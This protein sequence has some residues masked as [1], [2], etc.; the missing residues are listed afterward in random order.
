MIDNKSCANNCTSVFFRYWC[1]T[2]AFSAVVSYLTKKQ[3]QI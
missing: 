1:R 2:R 3:L